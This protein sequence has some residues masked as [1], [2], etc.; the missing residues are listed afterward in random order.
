MVA[1]EIG[2]NSKFLVNQPG[3]NFV[4]SRFYSIHKSLEKEQMV[5]IQMTIMIK[6]VK[7]NILTLCKEVMNLTTTA[8]NCVLIYLNHH[9]EYCHE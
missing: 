6:F 1:A 8:H 7:G 5:C 3:H 2:V 9:T 4:S